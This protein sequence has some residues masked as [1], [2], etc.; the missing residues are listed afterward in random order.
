M[1]IGISL[2]FFSHPARQPVKPCSIVKA[3]TVSFS[4]SLLP[5]RTV[6]YDPTLD[7]ILQA[8]A[9]LTVKLPYP[10]TPIIRNHTHKSLSHIPDIV[11]IVKELD[12]FLNGFR[13]WVTA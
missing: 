2:P 9:K 12:M 6:L 5:K 1:Q 7:L 8:N 11:I 3:T 4:S 10:H 13:C